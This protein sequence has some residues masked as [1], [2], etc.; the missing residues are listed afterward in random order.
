MISAGYGELMQDIRWISHCKIS[1]TDLIHSF[2][3]AL[4]DRLID[5]LW[6]DWQCYPSAV[7]ARMSHS[8]DRNCWWNHCWQKKAI[9]SSMYHAAAARRRLWWRKYLLIYSL[10]HPSSPAGYD[11]SRPDVRV[12]SHQ[13][14]CL[15][16]CLCHTVGLLILSVYT[17]WRWFIQL[18]SV[19]KR[20]RT[21]SATLFPAFCSP[22]AIIVK[23]TDK[24]AIWS[25][26]ILA[27]NLRL[28]VY[29]H[30][31]IV[32][33]AFALTRWKKIWRWWAYSGATSNAAID[34]PNWR[35]I[36]DRCSGWN[37]RN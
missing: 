26:L 29:Y 13:S 37:G 17:I 36:V 19:S 32:M 28:H 1:L 11:Y 14:V 8:I 2:A 22:L 31:D 15:S 25:Q 3:A 7:G 27:Q 18:T 10:K 23:M 4:I 34:R 16:V 33:S 20:K 21:M 12:L 9:K 35:P 24:K 5:G 30:G 6:S